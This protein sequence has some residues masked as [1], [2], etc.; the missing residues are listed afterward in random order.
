MNQISKVALGGYIYCSALLRA[1]GLS[2]VAAVDGGVVVAGE[3]PREAV[4]GGDGY[5][6]WREE[7]VLDGC[8][9]GYILIARD[10]GAAA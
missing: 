2:V 5:R 6:S 9:G 3:C 7:G 4:V 8:G 10:A 1:K